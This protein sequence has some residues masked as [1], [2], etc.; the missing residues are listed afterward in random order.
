MPDPDRALF[1]AARAWRDAD[2]D[3]QTRAE[4]DELIAR[5]SEG[6]ASAR[7]DLNERFA[8]RLA[9]G[10]AG[11]RGPLGAGPMRMNRLVVRQAAAGLAR[12]L[13][14][15][16]TVV[17]GFDAR[18]G[19]A[20][21]ALDTARVMAAAGLRARLFDATCPT[22]TLAFAVR[23]L[24]ADAGV[25]CTASHNPPRDN[26]YKVYVGDGAQIIP[27][28]DAE[29]AA[30][31]E[32]AAS[33][34]VEVSAP[35]DPAIER[36]GEAVVA[37]YL[38]HVRSVVGT[39]PAPGAPIRIVYSPLHGVGGAVTLEAL[40]QAGFDDVVVVAEQFAP[41]PDFPTVAFPNPEE[42]GAL[43]LASALAGRVEADVVIANDPDA[44]RLGVMIPDPSD[45]EVLVALTGNQVGALLAQHQ[46]AT[47]EGS[48]RLV[49]TTVVSSQ[50][51]RSQAEAA[52]V[53]YA[54]VPTGFKWVV[55]PGIDHPDE[56][57]VFGF[58]EALGF[59]VDPY[60]RDKDGISAAVCFALLVAAAKDEGQ[61]VW[62]R[63]E[64]LARRFG[65]HVTRSVSWRVD[66]ADG[67]AR[68]AAAMTELR[69]RSVTAI[70]GT[71]VRSVRDLATE[72]DAEVHADV[73]VLELVD[74]SRM[75]LRPSGTE[76]KLKLYAEVVEPVPDGSDG[77]ARALGDGARRLDA[78]IDAVASSLLGWLGPLG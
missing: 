42:P 17:V 9:F 61:L 6:D 77:Y 21:F 19:S 32:A 72:A 5:A 64:Q 1:D 20:A 7:A 73:V 50:L 74:G 57:F 48:D 22:P 14:P 33:G 3:G 39:R 23:H 45:P 68:L 44:D 43:D 29:I 60:V 12:W 66:G 2:P 71:A 63:L 53:H 52:G 10:T 46:L 38:E 37:A 76:P 28:V 56:R 11:L 18:H 58:E 59:S 78:L 4:L 51:L 65:A 49:V 30:A 47:T 54:E 70:G 25:M 67:P 31:I 69:Q 41:D 27:P 55:R 34:T 36:L 35:D 13:G 16:S 75:A 24:A 62:D 26:G 8:G 15:G 40:R